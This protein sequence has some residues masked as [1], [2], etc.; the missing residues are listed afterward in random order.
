MIPTVIFFGVKSKYIGVIFNDIKLY[1]IIKKIYS[2][3]INIYKLTLKNI[4]FKN[5][6]EANLL[7]SHGQVKNFK[8]QR[9]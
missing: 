7:E 9:L 1:E 8:I 4:Y 6:V 3:I 2:I 5:T